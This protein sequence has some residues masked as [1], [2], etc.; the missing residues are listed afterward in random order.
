[1]EIQRDLYLHRLIVRKHNGMIKIITGIRRCGKSY[2]LH[3]LFYNHLLETTDK[4]HIIRFAFDSSEYLALIG[5]DILNLQKEKRLVDPRKFMQYISARLKDDKMYYLLLDEVQMLDGFETVLNSY[6]RH[7]NLDIYVTGSN[8]KFLSTDII[9][10]FAGR[11]DQIH[12]M[13]LSFS[14]YC[15]IRPN[16][17]LIEA[18]D[19]YMIYGGLPD[20]ALMQTQEQK[21]AYLTSLMGQVYLKDILRRYN[22]HTDSVIGELTDIIASD[23]SSLTNPLKLAN[24]FVTV[25]KIKVSVPTVAKYISYL[26]EA[27]IVK[28]ALRYD[29]RGKKYINTPYKLY[30]EDTGLRNARL[31]FRQT[32]PTY[33]MENIIF[34]E[35]CRRGYSVD[36]GVVSVRETDSGGREVKKQLEIDFVANQGSRRYY[37]Q[38][39]RAV[40]DGDKRRQEMRPFDNT[41]DSFKKILIVGYPLKPRRDEKGYVVMGITD[42]LLNADSLEY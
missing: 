37:I 32:E 23:M 13:P 18:L 5:E 22:L 42:F 29:V 31:S 30:F 25:K 11:G 41:R 8:S 15:S 27:F 14:E 3:T 2:L 24:T 19:D 40:P 38:S 12:I 6:L 26:E 39:A 16:E 34:N 10:E 33:L 36:T 35:L 7:K 1:M 17:N 20:C 9:T 21:T 28:K 4:D